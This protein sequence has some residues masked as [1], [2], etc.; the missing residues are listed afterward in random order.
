MGPV[1][2]NVLLKEELDAELN[3]EN[4]VLQMLDVLPLKLN[5]GIKKILKIVLE[6]KLMISNAQ[7]TN[8]LVTLVT[9]LVKLQEV[10][11]AEK[12]LLLVVLKDN[13][14]MVLGPTIVT[15]T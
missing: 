15:I 4:V 3:S 7:L 2:I 13:V 9:I 12:I 10:K 11:H 1:K 14:I 6:I 8:G 5:I